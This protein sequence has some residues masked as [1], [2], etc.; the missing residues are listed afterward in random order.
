MD[1]ADL[2]GGP[3]RHG[4]D[5]ADPL[6]HLSLRDDQEVLHAPRT[7]QVTE[8][9]DTRHVG[10]TERQTPPTARYHSVTRSDPQVSFSLTFHS[11]APPTSVVPSR[12]PAGR[13]P[14]PPPTPHAQG[15]DT[16]GHSRAERRKE[17]RSTL[18]KHN[19]TAQLKAGGGGYTS[20][21]SRRAGTGE[22]VNLLVLVLLRTR[23]GSELIS[24][25]VTMCSSL[26]LFL[27]VRDPKGK[28]IS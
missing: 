4:D 6:R 2:C 28:R 24:W 21:L 16:P 13:R 15:P 26:F 8:D 18:H 22:F 25:R 12:R 10:P 1:V 20:A 9:T 3:S 23:C 5:A 19:H 27:R 11:R 14:A 7:P 17:A